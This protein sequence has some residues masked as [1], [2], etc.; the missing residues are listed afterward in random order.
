MLPFVLRRLLTT[1]PV[2]AV[3]SVVCF[4]LMHAVPGG[5]AGM[6]AEN[7]RSSP[8][9]IARIRESFGLDD[10]LPL[11]YGRWL[12]RV[13]LH[14][15]FGTSFTTGEPVRKMILR[16]FPATIELVGTAFT[17]A[18]VLSLL[19][20]ILAAVKAN[21]R[22]D[23]AIAVA[24][25]VVISIPIFWSGLV[26]MT[27]FSVKW[28]LLPPGGTHTI[29]QPFSVVDHLRHLLMPASV[30]AAALVAT[31]SRYLHVSLVEILQTDYVR[32]ARAK[33]VS[34]AR[35]VVVHALRNAIM[36]LLNVIALNAPLLLT[37]AVIVETMFGWPGIGRL[38]H[39]GL[40]R[41]DYGRVMAVVFVSSVAIVLSNS[42]VDVL[43][44][45]V[46]PR[47]REA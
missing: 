25:L 32:V 41:M 21:T 46:D 14:G 39:D 10:P 13:V 22:I 33:G 44:G 37:G 8:E 34:F 24:S 15:D 2:L 7:P 42:F 36:P 16:A 43:H 27:L 28:H 4:A 45:I 35:V 9:D 11:Q 23:A 30:L 26:L 47:T 29:G 38:F 1:V 6:L 18:L 31:W 5:P 19:L 3:T 12:G 17:I 20:G 40:L